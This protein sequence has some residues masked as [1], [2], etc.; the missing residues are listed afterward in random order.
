MVSPTGFIIADSRSYHA[1]QISEARFI[2]NDYRVPAGIGQRF[3]ENRP[4]GDEGR[5]TLSS[6]RLTNVDLALMKSIKLNEAAA[7][8]IRVESYNLFNH[9]NRS[10]PNFIIENSGGHGF[11]DGGELDTTARKIRFAV[12]LTF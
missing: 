7:L 3:A 6:P 5:N 10:I 11:A 4:F 8:H 12:K 9:P 2:Y 1:G